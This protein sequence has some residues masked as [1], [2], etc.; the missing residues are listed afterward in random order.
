MIRRPPRSTLFPY[1]TLFRSQGGDDRQTADEFRN[2]AEFEQIL[3]LQ[4]LQDL[5]GLALIRAAHLG[6]EADRRTLTALG[7]DLFEPGKRATADEQNVGGVDLQK[8]LLRVLA[9][10]LRRHR[11]DGALHD[12]QER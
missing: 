3:R 7:D 4:I 2:Q 5:A 1:T 11:G 8:F 6:A 10:A 9:S 12:P